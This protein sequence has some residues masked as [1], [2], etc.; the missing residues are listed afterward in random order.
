MGAATD[1]CVIDASSTAVGSAV[2]ARPRDA[3]AAAVLDLPTVDLEQVLAAAS[4]QVRMD[5]K[6]LLTPEQF[7]TL[8]YSI[9][10]RFHA[11]EIDER[12]EFGYESVYFDTAD[13]ALFCN[14][15]QGRRRRFKVRTRSYL[16]SGQCMFE[17]KL[18]GRRGQTIK[19]RLPYCYADRASMTAAATA[20]LDSTL[21]GECLPLPPLAPVLTTSYRRS[22]LVDL[23]AGDRLT[24]DVDLVCAD[25]ADLVCGGDHVLVESKSTGAGSAVDRAL[26]AL[27]VRPV[28]ISKYCVA[29]ALLHPEIPANRWNRTLRQD[30]QWQPRRVPQ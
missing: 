13:L 28:S 29:V 7:T 16:D 27:G 30:F 22:T 10:G 6:Y 5:R 11:L 17:I 1:P 24:C 26:A 23:T 20:F 19:H 12:R 25:E 18:K 14:H 8:A 4:L 9:R 2:R 15:R 21:S 3:L